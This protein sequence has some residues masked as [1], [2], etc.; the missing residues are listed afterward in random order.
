MLHLMKKYY[1]ED[2]EDDELANMWW[3]RISHFYM[4]FY[5]YQYATG[6]SAAYSL[7][8]GIESGDSA[9]ID[10]YMNF[11]ASGSSQYPL[12]TLKATG[13]DMSTTQPVDELLA[14]CDR[15]VDLLF[16]NGLRR[17]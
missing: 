7:S 9:K 2:F 13:V 11:L 12:D 8:R 4:N 15:L 14:E 3:S 1:D 5:V 10:V 16:R 17:H 6:I